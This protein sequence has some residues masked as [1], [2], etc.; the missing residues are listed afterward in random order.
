MISVNR[1]IVSQGKNKVDYT[2]NIPAPASNDNINVVDLEKNVPTPITN[3]IS[4]GN[5]TVRYTN[6]VNKPQKPF[7]TVKAGT[8]TT[9]FSEGGSDVTYT[10]ERIGNKIKVLGTIKYVNANASVGLAAG[11]HVILDFKH[12][13]IASKSALPSG[14]ICKVT[15]TE[16][17]G[18]YNTATK[19]AFEAD[20]SLVVAFNVST[21]ASLSLSEPREVKVAWIAD[22]E[23]LVW[24]T[25]IVDFSE[26]KLGA[27]N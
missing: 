26:A 14:T 20:G 22:G 16:L 2:G 27:S 12:P 18:N 19:D 23:D 9:A 3:E 21:A 25:Y 17:V 4:T 6:Q 24:E 10:L 11:N 13:N 1:V 5:T 15:H 7:V 8:Y